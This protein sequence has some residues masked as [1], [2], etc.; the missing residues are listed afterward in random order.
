MSGRRRRGVWR[1]E[2]TTEYL[3]Q[4]GGHIFDLPANYLDQLVKIGQAAQSQASKRRWIRHPLTEDVL[5]EIAA[6]YRA[7]T[8]GRP[9]LAIQQHFGLTSR[10]TA[11]YWVNRARAAGHLG[12]AIWGRAGENPQDHG[13]Y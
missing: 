4:L 8:G 6:T 7:S 9:T 11:S 5:R 1:P 3:R 10:R 2:R 13:G 12:P